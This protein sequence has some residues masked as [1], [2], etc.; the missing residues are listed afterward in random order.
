M[1]V[2]GARVRQRTIRFAHG[3]SPY[4]E[5]FDEDAFVRD[6]PTHPPSAGGNRGA[7][8]LKRLVHPASSSRSGEWHS[9]TFHPIMGCMPG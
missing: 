1:D 9:G 7:Q 4:P 5:V 2:Q 8:L 3:F 6:A